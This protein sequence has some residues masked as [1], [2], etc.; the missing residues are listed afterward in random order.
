MES[1]EFVNVCWAYLFSCE[2]CH[3]LCD[4]LVAYLLFLA[5]VLFT[6]FVY[7]CVAPFMAFLAGTKGEEE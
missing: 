6:P 3:S 7:L 4:A 2:W 5:L 1:V